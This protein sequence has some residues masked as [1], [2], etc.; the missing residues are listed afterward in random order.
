MFVTERLR[1]EPLEPL[2][3]AGLHAALDHPDVGT[4][5]GG[6]DVTT[7][8]ALRARIE[9]LAVGPAR[10]APG[11]RWW[12]FAVLLRA[13]PRIIG[14]LEATTYGDWGEIAYVF[15]P[16]WWGRGLASEASHWLVCHLA[17]RGVPE[18]WAA[19]DPDNTRSHR[20][21]LRIGFTR[22]DE[23]ERPLGSFLPGDDMFVRREPE[24]RPRAR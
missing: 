17:E 21:L 3:A 22:T 10:P 18:L 16:S 9:R 12:N 6:P 13:E 7:L 24:R 14:R 15:G 8:D 4:F 19:V 1:I 11:A 23:P 20:L 5:I 2:H